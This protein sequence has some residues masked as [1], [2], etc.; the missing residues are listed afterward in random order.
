M[1]ACIICQ[2]KCHKTKRKSY[3][4]LHIREKKNRKKAWTKADQVPMTAPVKKVKDN[5]TEK[6][7]LYPRPTLSKSYSYVNDKF[8]CVQ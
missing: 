2:W 1:C 6:K 7:C 3:N 5:Y 4:Q 8:K